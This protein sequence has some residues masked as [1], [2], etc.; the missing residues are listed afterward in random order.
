MEIY[1]RRE[2][3]RKGMK[4]FIIMMAM[5]S[6]VAVSFPEAVMAQEYENAPVSISKEKVRVDGKVC[7]S[8]IVQPKQTLYSIAK[9]YE[10]TVD[11]IHALNPSLKETG[12][13]QNS[14]ILIPTHDTSKKM[15]DQPEKLTGAPKDV[16]AHTKDA[17]E[18]EK[19]RKVK[20][21]QQKE[22][23]PV[24]EQKADE[25]KQKI[26]IRK[27]YEDLDVIAENYGVT[28]EAIMKANNLTGRKLS[29]RQ[30]L[31]IPLPGETAQD[32]VSEEVVEVAE[33]DTLATQE[34]PQVQDTLVQDPAIEDEKE[35]FVKKD[36]VNVSLLLPMKAS[37]ENPS[38]NNLD[39]Y[40]GVLLAVYD[41][42]EKGISTNLSVFDSADNTRQIAEE[43]LESSDVIIGPISSSDLGRTLEK[44]PKQTLTVSPLDP[45]AEA[46]ADSHRN[47]L[48]APTPHK[49]Q[50]EDLVSWLKEDCQPVDTVLIFTEKGAVP[51]DAVRQIKAAADSSGLVYIPF[52]YSILEG[53]DVMDPLKAN[54]TI[55]GTNRVLIASESEAFVNDV[56]RNLNILIHEKY[57]IVLYAPSKIRSFETI[58]VEN[59]HNTSM[60]VS[61]GYYI[62]YEDP[63]VKDFLLKY[64]A[65][66]RTEP[67][68][69]AF[70]G[71]DTA[72]Y[73]ISMCSRYGKRWSRKI[74]D[75]DRNMLQSTFRFRRIN[76]EGYVNTGIRRIVYGKDWSVT[77]M[78]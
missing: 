20:K 75:S 21:E 47:F 73:F 74:E 26:H 15:A 53:R 12:L 36:T 34:L 77:E 46:L 58:E 27:W 29:N 76:D 10:V 35:L 41:M 37:S 57:N 33:T 55:T 2:M 42:A 64:R 23:K 72:T 67:T 4:R 1:N 62:D 69:F 56:V 39:F 13:K 51:T 22:Q 70:Q 45:R 8:H 5:A 31:I 44:A 32:P 65:L 59:F 38:R 49:L 48:Q 61:L 11:E 14:I 78:K 28:V 50:Y 30:K 71:Y 66:Y 19:E 24:K 52:S 68:Q 43:D 40:S 60:H 6:A 18:K 17:V 63:R 54:M 9:A 7:Y 3:E 25:G 16:E